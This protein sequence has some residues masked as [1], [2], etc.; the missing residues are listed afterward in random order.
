MEDAYASSLSQPETWGGERGRA[1]LPEPIPQQ[2][3]GEGRSGSMGPQ[4]GMLASM[5]QPQQEPAQRPFLSPDRAISVEHSGGPY[6]AHNRELQPNSFRNERTGKVT[7]LS[8]PAPQQGDGI[9]VV[10]QFQQKDGTI[11]QQVRVPSINGAGQQTMVTQYRT[12]VPPELDPRMKARQE[13]DKRQADI[14]QS[15]ARA[16]NYGVRQPRAPS[17]QEI[18]DPKNPGQLIRVDTNVYQPGGSVGD[19]GV[20]GVSGKEPS[21]A[22]REESVQSGL[23]GFNSVVSSLRNNYDNLK[24]SGDIVSSGVNPASNMVRSLQSSPPGQFAGRTFGTKSQD[25]RNEINSSR[26]ILLTAIKNATG[27]TAKDMDTNADIQRWLKSVT[28]PAQS[29]ESN[30][31]VLDQLED[32]VARKAA[33]VTKLGGDTK[34]PKVVDRGGSLLID[35]T[36]VQVLS[37]NP[38]GTIKIRGKD[39]RTGTV[40][41]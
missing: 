19:P 33:A 38:D 24:N 13:F 4:R 37:R 27:M 2:W 40:R 15:R 9:Q 17:V 20:I 1:A 26:N 28:D 34:Q 36:P 25:A 31:A 6:D 5:A 21:S 3:G 23:E 7:Q 14:E 8:A 30:M 32:F 11:L 29:Y 39:G 35:G 18:V 22:K 16:T 10:Q 41:L 12:V